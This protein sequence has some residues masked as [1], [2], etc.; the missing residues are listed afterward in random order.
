MT[1]ALAVLALSA[2]QL[3]ADTEVEVGPRPHALDL[4]VYA[5]A[6]LLPGQSSL[7]LDGVDAVDFESAGMNFSLRLAYMPS[8]WVGVEA[9]A[10]YVNI[11]TAAAEG[12]EVYTLRG[13]VIGQYPARLSP[14]VLVGA[15][16]I[17]VTTP[18]PD[19]GSDMDV[20]G[21]WGAGA[22]YYFNNDVSTRL[23]ARHVMSGG[24]GG[25]LAHTV[26]VLA[27]LAF[28]LASL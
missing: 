19:M 10:G 12:A 6:Y 18:E 20:A 22:K 25:G 27:G 21:H 23:E 8:T 28:T 15:G 3:T 17:G 16:V 11:E 5:G 2:A 26:E 24:E 4:G 14:F 1:L 9:E 7:S 13:H